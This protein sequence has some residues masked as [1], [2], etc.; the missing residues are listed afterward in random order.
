MKDSGVMVSSGT[1]QQIIVSNNNNSIIPKETSTIMSVRK[2]PKKRKFDP[3]ELEESD[4]PSMSENHV[5]RVV[6]MPPQS[7][8]VDYS[9][10][11][12][13]KYQPGPE[14][15]PERRYETPPT[16]KIEDRSE[17]TSHKESDMLLEEVNN[18]HVPT[19]DVNLTRRINGRSDID[20]RE[21]MDHRVLAKKD[22]VYLP[23]KI[24]QAGCN[25]EVCV[26]FDHYEGKMVVFSDVLYSGK[27]N[28][29]SDASPSLQQ[30]HIGVRVCVRVGGAVNDGPTVFL[31]GFVNK[32]LNA[33]PRF[34]VKLL[35]QPNS[36]HVAKRAELRLLQP[37]WR[38][39]LED[40]EERN[41]QMP[42]TLQHVVPTLQPVNYNY[43]S[44]N[45][46]VHSSIS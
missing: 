32:I 4:K 46:V 27:Y 38:D 43:R 17:P 7:T 13:A 20:L 8:A 10:I 23:G 26:E 16:I 37:P 40:A 33:P 41:G 29:I 6:V 18:V 2:L 11:G 15:G 25:G 9:C 14:A 22:H 28:V 12:P 5:S 35:N 1:A 19:T 42:L 44:V 21:W 39:E 36:E 30:I 45:I 34:V 3:S 31:E 24:R